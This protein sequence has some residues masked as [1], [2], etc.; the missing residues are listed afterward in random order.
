MHKYAGHNISPFF[1][2]FGPQSLKKNTTYPTIYIYNIHHT[3]IH[4]NMAY[5]IQTFKYGKFLSN[6]SDFSY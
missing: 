2:D 1:E 6:V 5:T 4:I 3:Y